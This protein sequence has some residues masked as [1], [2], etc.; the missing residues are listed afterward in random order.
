MLIYLF[1]LN[2]IHNYL[3]PYNIFWKILESRQFRRNLIPTQNCSSWNIWRGWWWR[4]HLVS[5]L[6]NLFPRLQGFE[7]VSMT[8]V[9]SAS[10]NAAQMGSNQQKKEKGLGDHI[11]RLAKQTSHSQ[12]YLSFQSHMDKW[13]H[14]IILNWRF[15]E[16]SDPS[17]TLC[18]LI[19]S[20]DME[21]VIMFLRWTSVLYWSHKNPEKWR[22][23][24]FD[25]WSQKKITQAYNWWFLNDESIC[26]Y[27]KY[28]CQHAKSFLIQWPMRITGKYLHAINKYTKK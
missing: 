19:S 24:I 11:S 7:C 21:V 23:P 16:S 28:D 4:V 12:L 26:L 8:P 6:A 10:S 9:T 27:F 22:D 13:L 18:L 3:L 2:V 5:K 15:Q 17:K 20:D 14:Q 1:I 25:D